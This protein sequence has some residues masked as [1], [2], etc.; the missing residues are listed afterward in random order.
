MRRLT[1]PSARGG[2]G[3]AAPSTVPTGVHQLRHRWRRRVLVGFARL[4]LAGVQDLPYMC[5]VLY[6]YDM[7]RMRH[8]RY[9]N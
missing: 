1:R 5:C 8:E 4:A 9:K 7:Y 2:A 3:V 6:L